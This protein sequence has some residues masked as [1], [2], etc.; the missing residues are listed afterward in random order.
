MRKLVTIAILALA[1]AGIPATAFATSHHATTTVLTCNIPYG[2]AYP[3]ASPPYAQTYWAGVNNCNYQTRPK[4]VCDYRGVDNNYYGGWVESQTLFS[5]VSCP[6]LTVMEEAYA[7]WQPDGGGTI[8]EYQM[9][10]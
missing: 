5:K 4:I 2:N 8:S 1:F 10:P 7:Q 9:Y 3:N 6:L